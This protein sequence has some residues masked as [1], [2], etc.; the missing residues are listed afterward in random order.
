MDRSFYSSWVTRREALSGFG[1]AAAVSLLAPH[2]GAAQAVGQLSNKHTLEGIDPKAAIN[3][4][5]RRD[6][7]ALSDGNLYRQATAI[8]ARPPAKG[9]TSFT[10]HAPLELM[11]RYGLLPLVKPQ[12][13]EL[14]RLQIVAS[15]AAFGSGTP[16]PPP[17]SI[18]SFKNL[19]EAKQEFS[20]TFHAA[21]ADGLE[22]ITLQ[23]ASQFGTANLVH[24]LTPLALPTLTGA[25]HSHIGLWLLL[26]H[27]E[28]G[29]VDA[30]ALLRAG[31]RQ[32][33]GKPDLQLL[34]FDSMQI[35][36]D[37][38]LKQTPER[39]EQE[40]LAKLANPPQEERN[41]SSMHSLFEQGEGTGNADALFGD[42][43]R[44]DLTDD[45]ID[46]AFRALLRVCAHSMLQDDVG[47]AKFGWSH[48]LTLPQAATGLANLGGSRKLALASMLVWTVSYR[49]V[50]SH[51][52]LDFG[53]AP[54]PLP[55][56]ISLEEAL[57][58]SPQVAAARVWHAAPT[59]L[60]DVV[61]LLAT[62]ASIRN[63]QH[64]VKYTRACFDLCGF[65]PKHK[66]LYLAA[67]AHLA[68]LW[69]GERPAE[70]IL[71]NLLVR[72]DTPV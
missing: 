15:S 39:I 70:R 51:R 47:D 28:A 59:E 32:L 3:E 12:Q 69:V 53:W 22:A 63:D 61:Q 24:L 34:S 14:A 65:D 56:A 60:D 2:A 18:S 42:F 11:A 17:P 43:I 67:A 55:E 1:T 25:S 48:C 57:H 50:R 4:Y 7:S 21:D 13:R 64:L 66:Q 8:I 38:P 35:G 30:A 52:P 27:G 68:G 19:E 54:Q 16:A 46:A 20:Q 72:R 23:I 29:R 40:V 10:I 58:T 5:Q 41:N 71:D 26:R 33:A 31:V 44:H 36:S 49:S 62:E 6:L 37:R 45:Q 9:R